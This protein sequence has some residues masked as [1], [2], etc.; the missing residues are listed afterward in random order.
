MW[1]IFRGGMFQVFENTDNGLVYFAF[2]AGESGTVNVPQKRGHL[3]EKFKDKQG[4][5][6]WE[7][8]RRM[9]WGFLFPA[10]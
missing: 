8:R 7:G 6:R 1:G 9:L 10:T 4:L 3:S 2:G 5:S